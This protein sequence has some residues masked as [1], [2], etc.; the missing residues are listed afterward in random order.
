MCYFLLSRSVARIDV[1]LH[2]GRRENLTPPSLEKKNQR[3]GQK[4]KP[5]V[6]VQESGRLKGHGMGWEIRLDTIR[7]ENAGY[8]NAEM[9][10][11][12]NENCPKCD[13]AQCP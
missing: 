13:D 6:C 1:G 3:D 2:N 7:T 9:N 10:I 11:W 5:P 4:I 8:D 12:K